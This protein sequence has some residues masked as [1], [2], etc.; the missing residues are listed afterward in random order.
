MFRK[1]SMV[2]VCQC[3]ELSPTGGGV[4]LLRVLGVGHVIC[5]R[6]S[7]G[8]VI[9]VPESEVRQMSTDLL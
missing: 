7:L 6:L 8:R 5:Y 4:L 9:Y 1:C 2:Q 3:P